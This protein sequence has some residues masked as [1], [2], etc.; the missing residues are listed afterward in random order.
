[1]SVIGPFT[2]LEPAASM[3]SARLRSPLLILWLPLNVWFSSVDALPEESLLLVP[4][5]A[6]P[7][8]AS[9]ATINPLNAVLL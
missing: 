1:L 2:V 3:V 4:Q 7:T 8:L 9:T 6:T 5:A